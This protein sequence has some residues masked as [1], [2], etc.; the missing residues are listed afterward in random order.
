MVPKASGGWRPCV[1]Y[2][3]LNAVTEADR[4]AIPYIHDFA[5]RLSVAKIF[6][7]VYL[8]REYHQV[9]VAPENIAKTAS[10]IDYPIWF[11]RIVTDAFRFEECC[12][13][14]SATHG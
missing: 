3:R 8:V 4:Y 6:S 9:P 11:I 5:G 2:H 13:N 10:V 14:V 1:H 12:S 7:K